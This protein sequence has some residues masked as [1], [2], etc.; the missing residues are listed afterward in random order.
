MKEY[1][2]TRNE[3]KTIIQQVIIIEISDILLD[4]IL[5]YIMQSSDKVTQNFIA[6]VS[7]PHGDIIIIEF[8]YLVII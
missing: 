6:N 1:I 8:I 5:I 4:F 7:H 2:F 3:I